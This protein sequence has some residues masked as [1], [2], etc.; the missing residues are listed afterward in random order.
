[1]AGWLVAFSSLSQEPKKTS[2]AIYPIKAAGAVDKAVAQALSA[3]LSSELTPS[4]KLRVIE[5]AMLK[6][7]MERQAMNISDACDDTVCQV[8]IGKLVQAQ[9]IVTGDLVKLGAKYILSLRLIDIQTSTTEFS[10]KD[11]C[12]CAEDQLDQLVAVAAVKVR[13]Y[14]GDNVPLPALAQQQAP[15]APAGAGSLPADLGPIPL[16]KA[17]IYIFLRMPDDQGQAAIQEMLPNQCMVADA[18]PGPETFGNL[19]LNVEAGKTYYI[20]ATWINSEPQGWISAILVPEAQG[21]QWAQNCK[22]P[23]EMQPPETKK[24]KKKTRSK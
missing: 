24:A 9:K 14:C 4:P 10:T 17:R 7:V 18:D 12:T 5:E 6:E 22:R 8:E 16:G 19:N 11:E 20:E 3:L 15:A 1:M 21:R 23:E 2:V 13:N